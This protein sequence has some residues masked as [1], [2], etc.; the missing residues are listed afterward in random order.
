MMGY[1]FKTYFNL[2][3]NILRVLVGVFFPGFAVLARG[4]VVLIRGQSLP[5]AQ[6]LLLT[7]KCLF[8]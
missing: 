2:A 1:F 4:F 6:K 7:G 8:L 5:T 3:I